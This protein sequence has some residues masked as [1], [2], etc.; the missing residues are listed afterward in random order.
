MDITEAL[1][2]F[3]PYTPFIAFGLLMLAGCNLPISEEVV[4]I[5]SASIAATVVP[6]LTVQIYAGCW[7]GVYISDI[8]VYCIGRFL[9]RRVLDT[10]WGAAMRLPQKTGKVSGYLQKYGVV[11][12]L[13]GRLVPFGFRNILFTTAGLARMRAAKFLFFDVIPLTVTTSVYFYLGHLLGEKYETIFPL[14]DRL[15]FGIFGLFLL[16]LA[17]ILVRS[18]MVRL[19]GR[20]V[21]P[22]A[23]RSTG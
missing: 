10:R 8:M 16:I 20:R 13:L 3:A 17:V 22:E 6:Q 21:R 18:G 11:T 9:G 14:M 15:K 5:A 4:V 2:T 1:F 19:P 23:E 7:L 12:L